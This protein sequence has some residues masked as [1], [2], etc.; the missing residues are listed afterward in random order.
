[1][2]CRRDGCTHPATAPRASFFA[3]HDPVWLRRG[4][5]SRTCW[6]VATTPPKRA[7]RLCSNETCA[8]GDG[9][10]RKVFTP[11]QDRQR[12][13]CVRCSNTQWQREHNWARTKPGE[14]TRGV[15]DDMTP[16]QIEQRL[17]SLA[18]RRKQTRSWLRIQDAWQQRPGSEFH[19]VAMGDLT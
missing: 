14:D 1:M 13:C 19:N 7:L 5:C 17:A 9:G 4:Y 6:D 18:R 10:T 11:R 15:L 16:D 2:T 3:N 8:R 12:A